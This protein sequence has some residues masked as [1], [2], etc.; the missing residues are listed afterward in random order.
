VTALLLLIRRSASE[1]ESRVRG[2]LLEE[3]LGP[4]LRDPDGLRERAR[5]LGADLDRP[6][7]V[8]VALV[9]S[10]PAGRAL[11]AGHPPGRRPRRAGRTARRAGRAVPA[12]S[13]ARRRG[14]AGV[15]GPDHGRWA[16][17]SPSAGA[18]RRRGRPR[19]PPAT[20]RPSAAPRRWSPSAGP[21]GGQRRRA[22]L[23]RAAGRRGAETCAASSPPRSARCWTTTSGAAPTWSGTLR[24]WFDAGGSPARAAEALQVHVNTVTQRLE[25]VG[26]AARP[27]VVG[28]G[29][30]P[31]GAPGAAA[32]PA[33]RPRH[34]LT[35]GSASPCAP[36]SVGGPS[37]RTGTTSGAEVDAHGHH[38]RGGLPSGGRP[39][40]ARPGGRRDDGPAEARVRPAV[41]EQPGVPVPVPARGRLP[42]GVAVPGHRP[43]G[44]AVRLRP[45][46][47]H[48]APPVAAPRAGPASDDGLRT[49]I[50]IAQTLAL[51]SGL[52]FLGVVW[53]RHAGARRAFHDRVHA[54]RADQVAQAAQRPAPRPPAG[55]VVPP[56]PPPARRVPRPQRAPGVGRAPQRH[57]RRRGRLPLP[58]RRRRRRAPAR[59]GR[60]QPVRRG[61][62]LR[63]R[64]R[65]V[66]VPVGR[67]RPVVQATARQLREHYQEPAR[68]GASSR[69][70]AWQRPRQRGS[71]AA[72]PAEDAGQA[73]DRGPPP[74]RVRGNPRER[75]GPTPAP[76]QEP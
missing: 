22:G 46:A 49:A 45:R 24:A 52:F 58:R 35:E 13:G 56:E 54:T 76:G 37:L 30:R 27:R 44:A 11:A 57:H 75:G 53:V 55:P 17:R 21:A 43:R 20:S 3:L 18:V 66:G 32:A 12:G 14:G 16:G 42:L 6:H 1:A 74:Q 5:R 23:R 28:A 38:R 4:A 62:P 72:R 65:P 19:S 34:R 70:S 41:A 51:A 29:A 39:G 7:A 9:E 71:P 36:P 15:P 47:R 68:T 67:L 64:R 63:A 59:P 73:A 2:E 48:R 10:H 8:V 60:V 50:R 61:R 69:W 33:H 25:R 40:H 26:P 31:R